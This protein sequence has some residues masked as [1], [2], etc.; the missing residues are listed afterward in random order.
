MKTCE[1]PAFGN[2]EGV[3]VAFHA[4][5]VAGPFACELWAENGA[6]VIQI[7]STKTPD[8]SRTFKMPYCYLN[9]RKNI[10]DITCNMTTPEGREMLLKLI[11]TL[12]I[13]MEGNKGGTYEKWGL[14]DE[15]LWERNPK[16]VI[17][18]VSGFGQTGDPA[19]VKRAS[20]DAIGQAFGGAIAGNGYPDS[21][22]VKLGNTLGDY[23][24]A[25]W[26]AWAGLAALYNAQ[27]TGKGESIDVSMFEGMW[28]MKLNDVMRWT[29]DGELI[30]RTGNASPVSACIDNYLCAD[31]K[32]V[33][34]SASGASSVKNVL[35]FTGFD[36]NPKYADKTVL[37]V[38]E[39]EDMAVDA[40]VREICGQ[41][42]AAEIEKMMLN[43]GLAASIN[44]DMST[45]M[46]DP[47]VK[48]R[49]LFI[50][51][52]DEYM[53]EVIG[54]NVVPKMKNKP[55]KIWKGAPLYSGDTEDILEELGYDKEGI[56][57][58][59]DVGA[60]AH[61]LPN[62]GYKAPSRKK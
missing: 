2:L 24:T 53:G 13:F 51:W 50:S 59:Y 5:N 19:Y 36:K 34:L 15:V 61:Q 20:Y 55:G 45:I 58:L 62:G 30:P 37:L 57:K 35:R 27:K 14:T 32:Y 16:L 33:M 47:H 52:E 60:I 3:R 21:P 40:K 42:P 29:M 18:H 56:Q 49:E 48:A 38:S 44:H 39:P 43:C 25:M 46:D 6:T 41:H 10:M 7:E 31:G 54:T 22:P 9:E 4:V 23:I 8:Q 11:E 12:D 26:A 17:I 28:K 1:V